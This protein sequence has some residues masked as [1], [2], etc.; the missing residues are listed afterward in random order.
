MKPDFS[1]ALA[2]Y[3]EPLRVPD[4]A[5]LFQPGE[6][7]EG[8][9]IVLSGTVSVQLLDYESSPVWTRLASPHAVLGLAA[10]IG[11][12]PHPLRAIASSDCE[13]VFVS[14]DKVRSLITKNS[15]LG[16]WA[17]GIL[18][19]EETDIRRKVAMLG[20]DRKA[21]NGRRLPAA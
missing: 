1:V 15:T 17:L 19:E 16:V 9:Y 2:V 12:Y 8:I 21:V 7:P 5:I 11:G 14:S 13:V 6:W 20:G 10:A 4:G 18:A 3:G